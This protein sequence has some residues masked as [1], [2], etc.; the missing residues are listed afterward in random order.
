MIFIEYPRL[1]VFESVSEKINHYL[2]VSD[3]FATLKWMSS[4]S[5]IIEIMET[6][7]R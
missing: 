1:F 6:V 2:S 3:P 5:I 4:V 7:T